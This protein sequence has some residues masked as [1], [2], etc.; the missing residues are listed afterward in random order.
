MENS[1]FKEKTKQL[2]EKTKEVSNIIKLKMM[3][4]IEW[5]KRDIEKNSPVISTPKTLE[6]TISGAKD[7]A[8]NAF[9]DCE[10]AVGLES[11]IN[12]ILF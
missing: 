9:F 3:K 7:R 2:K 1:Q 10:C 11:G 6:E 12:F 4:A 8:Y 5:G